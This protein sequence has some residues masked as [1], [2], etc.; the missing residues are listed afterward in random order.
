MPVPFQSDSWK[1]RSTI[2][3]PFL[4]GVYSGTV[5]RA[6]GG[7]FDPTTRVVQVF[8]QAAH[9]FETWFNA[10][11]V[12]LDEGKT[13]STTYEGTPGG[14]STNEV[15][16][17][18]WTLETDS[19]T[20][21]YQFRWRFQHSFFLADGVVHPGYMRLY[22]SDDGLH[23]QVLQ[24]LYT[25]PMVN[26][27][28]AGSGGQAAFTTFPGCTAPIKIEGSGPNGE[29]AW[30]LAANLSFDAGGTDNSFT[31]FRAGLWYSLDGFAWTLGTDLSADPSFSGA[32]SFTAMFQAS[33]GRVFISS[34]SG[35]AHT[36]DDDDLFNATWANLPGLYNTAVYSMYGGTLLTAR[37]GSLI[38]QGFARV[39][40]D[41]GASFIDMSGPPVPVN[42]PAAPIKI[43]PAE[44]IIITNGG[45]TPTIETVAFYSADG[46]ETW[47]G[48]EV[49]TATGA[50]ERVA[51]AAV[52]QDGS[53]IVITG[54][55][56]FI[57]T[58]KARGVLL[59]RTICPLAN[60]G[61]AAAR[62]LPL[63][64]GVITPDCMEF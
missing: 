24:D 25:W 59:E 61:L 1:K 21:H 12:S 56:C 47:V 16:A 29:D 60:A 20:Y 33:N 5:S 14:T 37:H 4:T 10:A 58:D 11:R 64:G 31:F 50:G 15:V 49:W 36:D 43:G 35:L 44:A 53:P 51:F 41:N 63:C 54:D 42:F 27:I 9:H 38:S 13:W 46:G 7:S 40:C 34:S 3:M 17:G 57:S 23:F 22:I 45:G 55:S 28:P 52:K 19:G 39:S 32:D 8:G 18:A 2:G 26:D 62:R 48:G 30:W 6:I